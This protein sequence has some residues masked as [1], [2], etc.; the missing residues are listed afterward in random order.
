MQQFAQFA[1]I[2]LTFAPRRVFNRYLLQI[3]QIFGTKLAYAYI[4]TIVENQAA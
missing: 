2:E 3:L 1:A 4:T